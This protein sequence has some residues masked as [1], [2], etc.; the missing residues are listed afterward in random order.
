MPVSAGRVWVL[1]NRSSL[2]KLLQ[3]S[4]L[5]ITVARFF[6]KIPAADWWP[7]MWVNRLLL[8]A[9]D[10]VKKTSTRR[11]SRIH[12]I[13]VE[14]I[15]TRWREGGGVVVEKN[16][17]SQRTFHKNYCDLLTA[18]M[19]TKILA[20]Y[21]IISDKKMKYK[22]H[23]TAVRPTYY[24]VRIIFLPVCFWAT[25]CKTVCPTLSDRC[26]SCQCP[27]VTLEYC[28][29]TVGWIKIKLGMEVGLGPSHS[30]LGG[31]PAP[32]SQKGHNPIFGPCLLWPNGWM[33]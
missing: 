27:S 30:V 20:A 19:H 8:L 22:W 26:L 10:V 23:I 4:H 31:D 24:F 11:R 14:K 9:Y 17:N 6:V 32:P 18:I 5:G 29:Q 21:F 28:G 16:I 1:F 13:V 3:I 7:L 15:T 25:V 12:W 33:D 2:L